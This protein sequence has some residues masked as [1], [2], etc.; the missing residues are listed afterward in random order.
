MEQLGF[1][2]GG[3]FL[4]DGHVLKFAGFEDFATFFAFDVFGVF[5]SGHDLNARV[6]TH[7]CHAVSQEGSVRVKEG[8][9]G[10]YPE[11][12][13]GFQDVQ[14]DIGIPVF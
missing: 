10:S 2:F 7:R 4:F 3:R 9:S 1:F 6:F 13:S 5:F 14:K 11:G 8:S 12:N